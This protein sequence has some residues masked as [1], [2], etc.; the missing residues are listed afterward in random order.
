MTILLSFVN[1]LKGINMSWW[2]QTQDT[3]QNVAVTDATLYTQ[4]QYNQQAQGYQITP[5]HQ[6]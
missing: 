5:T 3:I 4:G 2:N 6:L 1:L